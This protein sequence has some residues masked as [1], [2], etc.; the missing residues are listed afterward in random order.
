MIIFDEMENTGEEPVMAYLQF[1]S[2]YFL[3]GIRDKPSRSSG[4]IACYQ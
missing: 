2:W 4:R 1:L 3:E